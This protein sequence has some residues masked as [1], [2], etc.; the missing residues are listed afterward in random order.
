[1]NFHKNVL[2]SLMLFVIPL[3]VYADEM[4]LNIE[5]ADEIE[6]VVYDLFMQ[7]DFTYEEYVDLVDLLNQP[8]DSSE[9]F[10]L[11][12]YLHVF[13]ANDEAQKQTQPRYYSHT[14]I[15]QELTG[16]QRYR[17]RIN[18]HLPLTE[19][20]SLRSESRREFT[21]KDRFA[22]RSVRFQRDSGF[23][24]GLTAGNYQ[25]HF[26]LDLLFGSRR[27]LLDS[28]T[29]Y[30]VESFLFPDA[31]A[32]NGLLL[33]SVVGTIS[34]D[35]FYSTD[36]DTRHHLQVIGVSGHKKYS[37]NKAGV[38]FLGT[39]IQNR[40][41][42]KTLELG[43][44]SMSGD[45]RFHGGS[46][47][48]ETALQTS[49]GL[50]FGAVMVE[51]Q[52]RY[53]QS[54]AELAVWHYS[55]NWQ[56][57]FGSATATAFERD[58]HIAEVDFVVGNK[59]ANQTGTELTAQTEISPKITL[60]SSLRAGG[61]S[62]DSLKCIIRN[63]LLCDVTDKYK[64]GLFYN[65]RFQRMPGHP[66]SGTEFGIENEYRNERVSLRQRTSLH[67]GS[68]SRLN[69]SFGVR[70]RQNDFVSYQL[71]ASLRGL[72]NGFRPTRY[73]SAQSEIALFASMLVTCQVTMRTT[74]ETI[75][76]AQLTKML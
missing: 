10:L 22:S 62:A 49:R 64:A 24:R 23:I 69:V 47:L 14:R 67:T 45:I 8:L 33:N 51:M 63:R 2:L 54:T 17:Y 25:K 3:A 30:S 27:K 16:N 68:P 53:N 19:H 11:R 32:F 65:D 40:E 50:R 37:R 4:M 41:T 1:M 35:I 29:L 31:R 61:Y 36:R 58:L 72:H 7:G 15:G 26:G 75:V 56:G 44:L 55:S 71:Y 18:M 73:V 34:G 9:L 46:V 6:D 60:T 20:W 42:G 74:E 66:Q 59:Y 39:Q 13:K 76:N 12:R 70:L 21:G 52:R 57:L 5:E 43:A 28:D 48:F 38:Q